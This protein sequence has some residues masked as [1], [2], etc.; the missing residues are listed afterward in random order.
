M[1]FMTAKFVLS[2]LPLAE[3]FEFVARHCRLLVSLVVRIL[4]F[5]AEFF[6]DVIVVTPSTYCRNDIIDIVSINVESQT[7]DKHQERNS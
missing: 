2:F 3:S 6:A 1:I 5:R 4:E 7:L